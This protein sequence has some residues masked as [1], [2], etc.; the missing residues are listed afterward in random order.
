MTQEKYI[1]IVKGSEDG[2]IAVMTSAKKAYNRALE[3]VN[4][5]IEQDKYGNLAYLK[6]HGFC[7]VEGEEDYGNIMCTVERFVMNR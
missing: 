7:T 5:S 1:Y 3:Y 6:E 4:V 2:N